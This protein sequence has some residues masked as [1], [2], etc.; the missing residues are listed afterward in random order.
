LRAEKME[1][2]T[3]LEVLVA[4]AVS[5]L[6]ILSVYGLFSPVSEA[7][8]RLEDE[9]GAYHEARVFFDR[10]GKELRSAAIGSRYNDSRFEGG[11]T[12]DDGSFL[13]FTTFSGVLMDGKGGGI[14]LV[15][16]ELHAG[17]GDEEGELW[18]S[19]TPLPLRQGEK[20]RAVRLS[21]RIAQ[22]GF[23]F[24][25]GTAWRDEWREGAPRMVEVSLMLR[26]DERDIPFR[27]LFEISRIAAR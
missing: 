1:G 4:V 11:R 25:D 21:K 20:T 17:K 24:H 13:E 5:A 3:L 6:I 26:S 15:R 7:R 22:G 2:F 19:E 16:Y 27:T 9:G 8:D 18:R 23:R 10:L 14:T 12:A